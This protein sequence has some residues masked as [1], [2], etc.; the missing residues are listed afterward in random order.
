VARILD[1]EGIDRPTDE[2]GEIYLRWSEQ[3]TTSFEYSGEVAARRTPDG[4]SSLG[5][6]GWLD[7][8]GFLFLADRRTDMII[9]GGANIYPAE[10]EAALSEHA[11]VVDAAVV[12]VADP[13]WGNRV[14]AIVPLR[15]GDAVPTAEDLRVRCRERLA[16][17]KV[18]RT[19]EFTEQL[20][21]SAAGKLRR[22]AL[23]T[24]DA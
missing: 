3:A 22:S 12:G 13:E 20:P 17:Y 8:D 14:H 2:V 5:D 4:F 11:D 9:S 18:P 7:D 15:K 1:E 23:G 21:R 24:P 16:A 6:L 10:I 19:Y